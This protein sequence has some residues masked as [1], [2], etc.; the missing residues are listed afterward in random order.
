VLAHGGF[1]DGS[2][3]EGV[4]RALKKDSSD[5]SAVNPTDSLAGNMAATH[6]VIDAL[7]SHS[8]GGVGRHGS[9]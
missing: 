6:A 2:G 4:Y 8:Y 1:V 5:V 3:W 7:E 9:W